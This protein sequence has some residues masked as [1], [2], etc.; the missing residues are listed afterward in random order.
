[1]AAYD[2]RPPPTNTYEWS[3]LERLPISEAVNRRFAG[4][5]DILQ[6]V[7]VD[8][9]VLYVDI[10]RVRRPSLSIGVD[11]DRSAFERSV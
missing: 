3:G 7:E 9:A 2:I 6:V 5:G 11:S 10:D 8:V 4:L 1:L